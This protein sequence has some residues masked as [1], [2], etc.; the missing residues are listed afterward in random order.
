MCSSDLKDKRAFAATMI[1][2]GGVCVQT[3]Q[4][5]GA[6]HSLA[7]QLSLSAPRPVNIGLCYGFKGVPPQTEQF[8]RLLWPQ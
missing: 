8:L 6:Q 1:T 7:P 4:M 3:E 5:D 2:V